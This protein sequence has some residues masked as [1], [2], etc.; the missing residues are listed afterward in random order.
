MKTFLILIV[1]A[2]S[3]AGQI[4]GPTS[5]VRKGAGEL[6]AGDCATSGDT[7]LSSAN[8]RGVKV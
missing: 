6:S 4:F 8:N 2:A 7:E 1:F 5:R 3:L